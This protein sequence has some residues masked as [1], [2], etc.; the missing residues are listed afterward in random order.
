MPP[1]KQ[2]KSQYATPVGV[3]S[4]PLPARDHHMTLP[5]SHCHGLP[6]ANVS[7]GRGATSDT[8]RGQGTVASAASRS[9]HDNHADGGASR[10]AE[11]S[12]TGQFT[13]LLAGEVRNLCFRLRAVVRRKPD[14]LPFG[15]V[16]ARV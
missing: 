3:A 7:R 11:A 1:R 9:S 2:R 12:R 14:A 4:S 16:E 13:S 10:A 5:R 15:D 8:P 6:S